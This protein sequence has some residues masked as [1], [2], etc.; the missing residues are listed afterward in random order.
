MLEA[1][2]RLPRSP[3]YGI[4]VWRS[5]NDFVDYEIGWDDL[6]RD[7]VWA[8]E[9]LLAAGVTGDDH[10]LI[11]TPNHESPWL[12]P[13]VRALRQIGATY[14]PAEIYGWDCARTLSVLEQMPISV[15]IGL[16]GETLA[17][18]RAQKPDLAAVFANVKIVW[19]R[20]EAHA[21]LVGSEVNSVLMAILGPALGMASPSAPDVLRVDAA[22]WVIREAGGE[23]LV[24]ATDARTARITDVP[25]GVPGRVTTAEDALLIQL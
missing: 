10:V 21:E 18:V 22:E 2:A 20:P 12:S 17:G 24:S 23:L 9:Q 3:I 5:G 8:R 14:T 11:T 7:V 19:A 4:G 16:S 13:V 6:R 25:A 1:A 15:V